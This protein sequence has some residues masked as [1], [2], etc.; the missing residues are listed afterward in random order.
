MNIGLWI[1]QILLALHTAMGAVWKVSNSEQAAAG[2]SAIPHAFWLGL[3]PFEL[4]C[5]VALGLGGWFKAGA[6]FVPIAAVCVAGEMLTF[7]AVNALSGKLD[8]SSVMYWLVVA[9][10]CGFLAFGRFVLAP[11]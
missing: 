5:A 9:V 8:L 11:L 2:L 1:L 6:P 4:A 7:C 3:I 10:L